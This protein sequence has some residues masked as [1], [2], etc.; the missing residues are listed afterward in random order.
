MRLRLM[1]SFVLIVFVAIV[2][3]VLIA[4]FGAAAEVRNFMYRGGAS[5][6]EGLVAAL[7]DYYSTN[8]GWDGAQSLLERAG[9]GRGAGRGVGVASAESQRLQLA[10]AQGQI[11]ADTQNPPAA[12]RLSAAELE[13]AIPLHR[14]SQIAGY[15]LP[16]QGA[17]F[18]LGAESQL[19]QRISRAGLIAALVAGGLSLLLALLLAHGLLR[20]VR[21]LTLASARM[22]QG[23]LSQ[24]VPVRGEDELAHLG[25]TFN[26]MAASLQQAETSRRALTA[27]IAHELRNPL[28]V[29]RANLEALQDGIYPMNAENL[30]PILE[31]NLL[32]TRLV[33]DLRTLALAEAGETQLECQSVDLAALVRRVA[34]RFAAPAGAR[35]ITI[36]VQVEA[37]SGKLCAYADPGRLEQ[38]LGNLLSNALRYTPQ[39]GR[40]ELTCSLAGGQAQVQVHDSGPGIPADALPH[41]FD[42][43]YRA[44]RA[45]SRTDGGAGLGLAIARQFTEAHGGQLTAA[46]HP[47]GGAIFTLRLPAYPPEKCQEPG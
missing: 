46:N 21:E 5:G 40:L 28:A 2:T 22:S 38:V 26:Q 18:S 43:F 34:E 32:L 15:L 41:V 37:Q 9:H 47:S 45:R 35:Q 27:D 36:E 10:D 25:R 24:R 19:V 29:Q 1:L 17:A 39:N 33:E 4:R 11:L 30:Q 42:R 23:D 14:G 7:E 16:E 8:S 13:R 6:T 12:A 3:V 20:P 44:D 31:Q